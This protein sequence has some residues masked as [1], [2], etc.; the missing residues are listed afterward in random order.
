MYE[1]GHTK[2]THIGVSSLDDLQ[3]TLAAFGQ[4]TTDRFAPAAFT[5]NTDVHLVN[6]PETRA[7]MQAHAS[8]ADG[9]AKFLEKFEKVCVYVCVCVQAAV[10]VASNYQIE[11][12][13]Q[14][15]QPEARKQLNDNFT[16]KSEFLFP[17]LPFSPFRCSTRWCTLANRDVLPQR[18]CEMPRSCEGRAILLKCM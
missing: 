3:E 4:A 17:S 15:K 18:S 11:R 6:D 1:E 10:Q 7:I 13:T 8:E 5:V 2:H 16:F 12:R 9:K 14:Q